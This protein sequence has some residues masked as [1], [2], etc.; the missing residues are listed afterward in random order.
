MGASKTYAPRGSKP[1]P[2]VGDAFVKP[3]MPNKG[4]K[5]NSTIRRDISSISTGSEVSK[6]SRSAFSPASFASSQT[7]GASHDGLAPPVLE[8]SP[9]SKS[10]AALRNAISK[11]KAER[12]KVVKPSNDGP[13]AKGDDEDPV[14]AMSGR[15]LLRKRIESARTEGRLNIAAMGLSEFPKEVLQ[16]YDLDTSDG[17]GAAWYE[18]VDIRR[19]NAADNEFQH[20]DGIFPDQSAEDLRLEDDESKGTIFGGLESLDIHG[21]LLHSLNAG[22]R[23]LEHLTSLNLS[24][25]RLGNDCFQTISE[26]KSLTELRI[27]ENALAGGLPGSLYEL[28]N[29]EVLDVHGN[30]ISEIP[31]GIHALVSLRSLTLAG[32]QLRAVPFHTL[33]SLPLT[34][35]N[36]NRNRISGRLLPLGFE[37]FALLKSLDVSANALTSICDDHD[38]SMPELQTLK[39][40]ENR[41]TTLPD[42]S[43]WTSLATLSANNNNLSS[44]PEGMI[45][46]P[47]L[48]N[49]D[50][51]G[52]NFKKLDDQIGMM[53]GLTS[54]SIASNPLR[55][56]RFLTMDTDNMKRELRNR[57]LPAESESVLDDAGGVVDSV[58]P[59]AKAHESGS[60]AWQLKAG[61]VLDRSSTSLKTIVSSDIERLQASPARS[62][63]A[64]HNVLSSI[65]TCISLLGATLTLLDVSHNK[66][67]GGSYLSEQLHL[68]KLRELNLASNTLT[69]L[70]P[71]LKYLFA[72]E[73]Q[74]LNVSFNRLSVIP[75]MRTT[76]PE[77]RS[78]LASDNAINELPADSARGLWVC[79]V[80]R[81][82][83]AHLEPALGLLES[84]GLKMLGVEGNRFRVP[85]RDVVEKGTGAVLAWLR[86]KMPLDYKA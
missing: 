49:V 19:L 35:L 73:L 39:V 9:Q 7:S 82:D 74:S 15:G 84:E 67:T 26:I 29:L 1:R 18:S 46:L 50:F 5:P 80:S 45:T 37:G 62:L 43:T 14:S 48:R 71:I 10:S 11:A 68:P 38:V 36:L 77:L 55:E 40:G 76:Y 28:T 81:N 17:S 57:L 70:S 51:T 44:I 21:N 3:A 64:H 42:I 20:L 75:A 78:V 41:F 83:I 13:H 54:F 63:V 22:L 27:A 16:M 52:N 56:R 34:E 24:K 8:G 65:P 12:R 58:P 59:G 32:N 53:E 2:A 61:G 66:L 4:L 6:D 85:R 69:S 79:D 47:R 33:A 60:T 86:D 30:S 23:H 72:P 31:E 25:N